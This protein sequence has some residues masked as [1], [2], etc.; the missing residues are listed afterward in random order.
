MQRS[1]SEWEFIFQFNPPLRCWALLI[2]WM[3]WP[4]SLIGW[5]HREIG[6]QIR[7]PQ[8]ALVAP[9]VSADKPKKKNAPLAKR[10]P[11]LAAPLSFRAR[12]RK[13]SRA[14]SWCRRRTQRGASNRNGADRFRQSR[15]FFA[16]RPDDPSASIWLWDAGSRHR[17]HRTLQRVRQRR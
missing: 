1:V 8:L 4:S 17:R 6:R 15:S 3:S 14:R 13:L 11:E 9:K 7:A 5:Q 2:N 12:D 10:P 16:R